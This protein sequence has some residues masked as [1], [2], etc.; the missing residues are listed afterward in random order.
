M[1]QSCKLIYCSLV[2]HTLVTLLHR[3]FVETGHLRMSDPSVVEVSWARCEEAAR[4]AT[5]VLSQYRSTFTL[6][7]APYLIVSFIVLTSFQSS[8]QRPRVMAHLLRP[9]FMCG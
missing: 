9:P 2:Y 5:N 3:P 7:R 6:A 1:P 4:D 8:R